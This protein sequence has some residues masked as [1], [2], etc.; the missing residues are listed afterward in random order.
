MMAHEFKKVTKA[1]FDAFI[2]AYP[3]KLVRNVSTI[4]E[5]PNVN[6]NDFER[7]PY[8]PDSVVASFMADATPSNYHV[9]A[10]INAPVDDDGTRDTATPLLDKNGREVKEG[11]RIRKH[12]GSSY[13]PETGNVQHHR[14]HTVLI[15]DKATKYESWSM[16]DC[17]NRLRGSEFEII[18]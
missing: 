7:A 1:E 15:R 18:E 2:A 9:I 14:E 3:R 12:W 16:D 5:P 13:S 11:D 17:H 8:W 6:F 4:C 10:D